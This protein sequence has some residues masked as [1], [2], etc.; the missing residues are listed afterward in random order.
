MNTMLH[1]ETLRGQWLFAAMGAGLVLILAVVGTY[2]AVW[3]PRDTASR[4]KSFLDALPAVLIL[5]F[6]GIAIFMLAYFTGK[7]AAPPN[8]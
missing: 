3:R 2:L 7:I 4:P 8:W 6:A 1:Y 5:T